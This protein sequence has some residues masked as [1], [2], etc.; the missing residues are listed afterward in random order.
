LQPKR[1]GPPEMEPLIV[2]TN[3]LV[4][5]ITRYPQEQYA[6]AAGLLESAEKLGQTVQVH[7]M[8]VA[9]AIFVP[10]GTAYRLT[11]AQAGLELMGLFEA[12]VWSV[13]EVEPLLAALTAY[14]E[15][16]LDFPELYLAEL[17]RSDRLRLVSFDRELIRYSRGLEPG[18]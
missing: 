18:R 6:A 8:H 15:S 7:P 14:P 2:D 3:I 17:A 10:E 11:P 9:E 5:L 16:G 12:S 4:R 1:F 13:R